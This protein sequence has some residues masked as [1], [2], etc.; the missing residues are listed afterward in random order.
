MLQ[1]FLM[2]NFSEILTQMET[3]CH[4][5]NCFSVNYLHKASKSECSL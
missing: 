2:S 3:G 5:D 4:D 1:V